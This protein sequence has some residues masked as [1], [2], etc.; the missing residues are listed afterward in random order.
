MV[1]DKPGGSVT[2]DSYDLAMRADPVV[3]EVYK[4]ITD[5]APVSAEDRDRQKGHHWFTG[6]FMQ[7]LIRKFGGEVP[8]WE[9]WLVEF[10]R[11]GGLRINGEPISLTA[12]GKLPE[13]WREL[14]PWQC[15]TLS[16]DM[17]G[18]YVLYPRARQVGANTLRAKLRISIKTV[19][20]YTHT[21]LILP[22]SEW[23]AHQLEGVYEVRET[24]EGEREQPKPCARSIPLARA[25]LLHF[26]GP[27]PTFAHTQ[28]EHL[29]A[30]HYFCD[31]RRSGKGHACGLCMN[32][33]H[34][35]WGNRRSNSW[36]R[37]AHTRS[38]DVV[39]PRRYL[40]KAKSKPGTLPLEVELY[41]PSRRASVRAS[42]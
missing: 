38:T 32:P 19:N 30:T 37:V 27:M 42:M 26:F 20:G 15:I 16:P 31:H 28:P 33:F 23:R 21:E 5:R 3:Y 40:L 10:A 39:P 8:L 7:P 25:C 1:M 35:N 9:E 13:K 34:I 41:H 2:E 17:H 11:L 14:W 18:E 36:E 29:I 24:K 4:C 12:D 6:T 22:E